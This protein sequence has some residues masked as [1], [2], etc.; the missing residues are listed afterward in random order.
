M[1]YPLFSDTL[2]YMLGIFRKNNKVRAIESLPLQLFNTETKKLEIFTPLKP[3]IAKVYSC[4]PTV[5][6]YIHIGNL[7]AFLLSDILRRTL[8]YNHYVVTSVMNFTDFGHLTDDG[9][10]GEDKIMKGLRREGK[11]ISL[12]AMRELTDYYIDAFLADTESLRLQP[13]TKYTR[14]SEYVHEQIQLIK[15]L[16]QKGYTYETSDGLY[17]DINKFPTY[18]RLG[19]INLEALKA[20]AR[21]ETNSEKR[22][23]ADFAI[24]KKGDLGW[25]SRWGK[26][27][28]GWHIECSAM[29]I[30]ELGKQ[31]DIH[32]GGIDNAPIHHNAEIAQCECATGK[33]FVNYWLHNEFLQIEGGK[34]GKS[35]GNAISLRQLHDRGFS[36]DDYRYWLLTAHYRS[37]VNFSFEALTAAKQA[38]FRLKRHLYEEYKG[39]ATKVAPVYLKRFH[40]HINNDLDTPKAIALLWEVVKD[41]QLSTG[42]KCATI[43]HMDYILQVGLRD[44]RDTAMRALGVVSVSDIPAD[45][46]ALIDERELARTARNWPEADRLRELI[47]LKGYI[48]EDSAQGPRV[49]KP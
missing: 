6:D 16:E 46:Q 35:L 34:I 29:A 47:T 1:T 8:E 21:V 10:E 23:P 17:F 19:N 25:D 18:G 2:V 15:T 12:E 11:E 31:I 20:G 26:G 27:F 3:G 42:E 40:A 36:G 45:V 7:R 9:D 14:A 44:E 28:P 24:W 22:H 49:S 13:P 48:V 39:K 41:E 32:T 4:G 43:Q 33:K 37:P 5:Y 30:A 38:L